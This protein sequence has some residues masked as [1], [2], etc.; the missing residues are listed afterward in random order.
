M[1][2]QLFFACF[3]I[4]VG[5]INISSGDNEN[6]TNQSEWLLY[7]RIATPYNYDLIWEEGIDTAIKDGANVILD[8]ASFSDEY[9]GRIVNPE[10]GL[11]DLRE[12]VEFVHEHYPSIHYMVYIAPLEMITSNCDMN[13]NGVDDDGKNSAFTDHPEWLQVGIDGKKAVFYGSMPGIPSWVDETSEDVW[14]SPSNPVYHD[15]I[16]NLAKQ[17]ASTGVDAVWFD[18]PFLC[19]NFGEGWQNQWTSV[20][21]YSRAAFYNDTGYFILPPPIS[22]NWDDEAWRAFVVWR[23]NQTNE[24]IDDFNTALKEVNPNIKLIIETS[25][26]ADV[27]ATQH[28]NSPVY[29]SDVCDVTAHEFCGPSV[30][31]QYYSW[32]EMMATLRFC[33]DIDN[34]RPSWLLSYVNKGYKNTID[35][36]R[37]HAGIVL[38]NSFNYYTSGNKGMTGIP[39]AEFNGKFLNWLSNHSNYY[40]INNIYSD[41]ALFFSHQTLDYLDKGSWEGYAYHDAWKGMAMML[42]ESNIPFHVITERDIYKLSQYKAIIMPCFA[43]MSNEQANM[44]RK[45]VENGGKIIATGETSLFNEEGIYQSDFQLSDVFGIHYSDVKGDKVYVNDYGKGKAIFTLEPIGKYYCWAAS[46]WANSGNK[47]KAEE[48]RLKL[49]YLYSLGKLE[50]EIEV[51][52]GVIAL[53]YIHEGGIEIRM[54]NLN[55]IS[56]GDAKPALQDVNIAVTIPKGMNIE[57]VSQ[58]DLLDSWKSLSYSV[59][60]NKIIV[61]ATIKEHSV[62]SLNTSTPDLTIS[63]QKP[64]EGFLYFLNKGIIPLSKTVI[65]GPVYIVANIE[66]LVGVD[67]VEFYIDYKLKYIDDSMPY[68]WFWDET[69]YGRHILRVIAYDIEGNIATDQLKVIIFNIS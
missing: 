25:V 29:L 23:Y 24:F 18:V 61:S 17:I 55:G 10:S 43:V 44:I 16:I 47:Q 62:I 8:W 49:I 40:N 28:G 50:R 35:V 48:H 30:A 22:P 20:D 56:Y 52:A 1:K 59:S 4:V 45:Y 51:D 12:R 9:Y 60:G 27:A 26:D 42:L 53:P 21:K 5:S 6:V 57:S 64:K 46:P 7:A 32:L 68:K 63:I 19:F 3:L 38:A 33:K 37:L 15:I 11:Q 67:K 34:R 58:L 41:I 65:L 14:L 36:A 69:V 39:D 31:V 2:I 66:S 54:V 13:K